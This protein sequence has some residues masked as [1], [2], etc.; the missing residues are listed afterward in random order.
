MSNIVEESPRLGTVVNMTSE[1]V[2]TIE[3]AVAITSQALRQ[4]V[5]EVEK[6]VIEN[7]TAIELVVAAMC[8]RGHVLIEA[9]PGTGKTTLAKTVATVCGQE[10]QRLQCT[11][12]L[13]PGDITGVS[14][15]NPATLT[16]EFRKGPVF[17][18]ILH[19][20]EIN[21]ATPKAQSA[22][23]EAMA[24]RQVSVDGVTYHLP[25]PFL[26]IATQNPVEHEGTYQLPEAQL[27]RFAV[28]ASMSYPS[29][30]SSVRLIT[31]HRA[32]P[33]TPSPVITTNDLER[34]SAVCESL[35]VDQKVA[36]YAVRLIEATRSHPDV[37]LGASP[38][39]TLAL[40]RVASAFAV[41]ANR[42]YVSIDDVKNAAVPVIAHRIV[43]TQRA[44]RQS[45]P[46]SDVVLEILNTLRV[47][48]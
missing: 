6:V 12:D 21:R 26:V 14:V 29:V 37:D 39:A 10:A 41:M 22:L 30:A 47:P 32:T 27:D 25:R 46:A 7:R 20:D 24:E 4:V 11:P 34:I 8:A 42:V 13:L 16:F 23:L 15:F 48:S 19:A 45:R 35:W 43:L 40:V 28:R 3:H 18:N 31:T 2:T 17:T 38:R 44:R 36:E 9:V 1:N 33:P 5:D